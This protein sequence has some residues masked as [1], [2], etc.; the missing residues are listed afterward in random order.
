MEHVNS[1]F[2]LSFMK[3][4]WSFAALFT[5]PQHIYIYS[6]QSLLLIK[7]PKIFDLASFGL[8]KMYHALNLMQMLLCPVQ[9]HVTYMLDEKLYFHQFCNSIGSTFPTCSSLGRWSLLF[10]F[11]KTADMLVHA[12]RLCRCSGTSL[13]FSKFFSSSW[14]VFVSMTTS[15]D[16]LLKPDNVELLSCSYSSVNHWNWIWFF[17]LFSA[18]QR[19]AVCVKT[20]GKQQEI[21]TS[22]SFW[23]YFSN[24]CLSNV[25]RSKHSYS[26]HSV[27]EDI[28]FLAFLKRHNEKSL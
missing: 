15:W 12:W 23:Y 3:S 10:Q 27:Q 22:V 7:L 19:P 4:Y 24:P 28:D 2:L 26:C 20:H 18:H 1:C 9:K 16:S 17:H 25:Y 6:F 5:W 8:G 13:G 14:G 11:F 21:M